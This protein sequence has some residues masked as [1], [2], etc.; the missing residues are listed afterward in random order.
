MMSLCRFKTFGSLVRHY[1]K[2]CGSKA[3]SPGIK[4][5]FTKTKK[6][7]A[8]KPKESQLEPSQKS[9]SSKEIIKQEKKLCAHNYDPLPVVLCRGE[10]A[11]VW[12][13]EEKVYIDFI[14][15]F[16][17]VNQGHC[18]PRILET[19]KKQSSLLHHTSRA[20]HSNQLAP[21]AEFIT[22]YFGYD[23]ILPMNTGVEGCETSVKL[24]RKWGYKSKKIPPCQAIVVTCDNNFWGRSIAAISS[25]T[26]PSAYENY[27]PYCPGFFNVP[28]NDPM[29]L[30]VSKIILRLYYRYLQSFFISQTESSQECLC[31]CFYGGTNSR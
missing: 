19:L 17:A 6:T 30:E 5:M 26:D 9:A 16:S 27:G 25:S 28:Y 20:F 13:V 7:K 14:G 8:K 1:A 21:Y 12:D 4:S 15:G 11:C 23:K 10:R 29:A 22:K 24:A 2:D 3:G 31:L 18:H